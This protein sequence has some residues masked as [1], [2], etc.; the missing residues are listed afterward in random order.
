MVKIGEAIAYGDEE[1]IE[2]M[3]DA[4]NDTKKVTIGLYQ[5]THKKFK[6]M[7]GVKNISLEKTAS[8]FVE[9]EIMNLDIVKYVQE[10][11]DK[12]EDDELYAAYD[13]EEIDKMEDAA[14]P[15]KR[16]TIKLSQEAHRRLK[17]VAGAQGRSLEKCASEIVEDK[18]NDIDVVQ[19][20]AD[21]FN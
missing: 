10:Y 3:E 13:Q 9:D 6:V 7:A 17:V 16:V 11:L 19:M 21:E 4:V 14:F 1:I 8:K 2:Q 20:V 5:K 15:R 12:D 18:I